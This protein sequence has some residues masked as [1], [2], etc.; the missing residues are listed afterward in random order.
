MTMFLMVLTMCVFCFAVACV[1]FGAANRED[2]DVRVARPVA[3]PGIHLP[4]AQAR[5]FADAAEAPLAASAGPQQV[6]LEVLL[7]QIER[8]VR[9]EQAAA[10][11]FLEA[12]TAASLHSRTTSPLVH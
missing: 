12:P 3:K 2:Q 8:H 10:E 5:F 1:A 4:L 9:L 7:L 6:P 11:S